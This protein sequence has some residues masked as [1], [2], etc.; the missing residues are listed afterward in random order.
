MDTRERMLRKE[1]AETKLSLD[2]LKARADYEKNDSKHHKLSELEQNGVEEQI[3]HRPE[4]G[5]R[6][7]VG[8]SI[9]A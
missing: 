2:K 4:E 8:W 9:L 7:C 3:R 5:L 6:A 1:F